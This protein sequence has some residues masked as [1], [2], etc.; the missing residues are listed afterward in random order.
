MQ[1]NF[2]F[3]GWGKHLQLAG[4][5]VLCAK[6]LF[7]IKCAINRLHGGKLYRKLF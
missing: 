4:E 2:A 6:Y 3:L 7:H 5:N 1:F